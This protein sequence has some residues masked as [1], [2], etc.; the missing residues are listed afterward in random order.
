[1]NYLI[2]PVRPWTEPVTESRRGA[3]LFRASWDDTLALL[4]YET[5]LLGAEHV[6]VQIDVTD[7][8]VRRDGMLRA[9]ARVGFPG[10]R[11][12]FA[13]VH[14]PLTYATDAYEDSYYHSRALKGWQANVRAIALALEALRAV[15]RYGVSR[16]GEQYR[17]WT[18]IAARPAEL[19]PERAARLIAEAAYPDHSDDQ[20][21]VVSGALLRGDG[22]ALTAAYR[23]ASK[24]AHPDLPGGD[25]NTM[26]LINNARDLLAASGGRS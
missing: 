2:R 5:G 4:A 6:I 15:D 1:M 10:V 20:L 23:L 7:G 9:H 18:A 25:S 22:D 26:A 8:E 14:G 17:G 21:A 11:I 19:T 16:R 13:S 3:H 24:R 12:S